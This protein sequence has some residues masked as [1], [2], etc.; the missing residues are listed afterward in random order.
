MLDGGR[1]GLL[2]DANDRQGLAT[3]LEA[4]IGSPQR[5]AALGEVGRSRVSQWYSLDQML[6]AYASLYRSLSRREG[7]LERG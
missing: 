6:E 4:L 7:T 3:A 1:A 2:V 5:R